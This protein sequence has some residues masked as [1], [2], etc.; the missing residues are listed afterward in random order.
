MLYMLSADKKIKIKVRLTKHLD[1]LSP[2]SGLHADPPSGVDAVLF[3]QVLTGPPRLSAQMQAHH[4]VQDAN[5][6]HGY[7]VEA[8][9]GDLHDHVIDPQGLQHS[10]YGRLLHPLW[11]VEDA[12]QGG[13]GN[14]T[15]H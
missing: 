10:A 8:H 9:S 14:S 2:A 5:H 7:E 1:D 12:V 3:P 6:H 11:Q 4:Q 13:V 15:D